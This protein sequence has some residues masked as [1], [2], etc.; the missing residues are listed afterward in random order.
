MVYKT[1]LSV[2]IIWHPEYEDGQKI[3][4]KL[5]SL[6][7]RNIG[8]PLIRSIGIPV[9]F[10]NNKPLKEINF[11]ESTNTAIVPLI[12]DEFVN[13]N[14]FSEYINLLYDEF[15]KGTN[16][17]GIYPIALSGNA[18]NASDKLSKL[19]FV[20]AYGK[21]VTSWEEIFSV[22]KFP[23]LHQ[24]C[25][26]LMDLDANHKKPPVKLFIS[27][28][29]HDDGLENAENFKKYVNDETQLDTFFDVNDIPYGSKFSDEIKSA[30][31]EAALVVFAV[32]LL[33]LMLFKKVN[34]EH[35][36]I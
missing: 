31:K 12:N 7:C 16:K 8:K 27:H 19:N 6:L 13:D 32:Q 10:R 17:I 11:D 18:Y 14:E 2:Y 34:K 26:L 25:R 5:F 3:A 1:P 22:V 36:H 33:L 24:L 20:K 4:N 28:S 29:K 15:A 9:Y 35:F 23:I 21:N 30:I